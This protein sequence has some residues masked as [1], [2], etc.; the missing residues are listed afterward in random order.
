MMQNTRGTC[1]Y[2]VL[3]AEHVEEEDILKV[4]KMVQCMIWLK[5]MQVT[6]IHDEG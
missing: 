2:G 3:L 5:L 1:N 6:P 4:I